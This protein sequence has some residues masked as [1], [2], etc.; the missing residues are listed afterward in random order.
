MFPE[1]ADGTR[2][3]GQQPTPKLWQL[4]GGL[5]IKRA[6]CLLIKLAA[7]LPSRIIF[8]FLSLLSQIF[9]ISYFIDPG[10]RRLRCSA[11]M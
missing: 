11:T 7:T 1:E 2:S 4:V 8:H 3:A 9:L 6:S 10:K 5:A